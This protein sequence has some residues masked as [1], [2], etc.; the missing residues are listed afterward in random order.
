MMKSTCR[1]RRFR[2]RRTGYCFPSSATTF[3]LS[4]RDCRQTSINVSSRD[5]FITHRVRW[6]IICHPHCPS[7]RGRMKMKSSRRWRPPPPLCLDASSHNFR[8][9]MLLSPRTHANATYLTC[10]RSHASVLCATGRAIK[11]AQVHVKRA[12]DRP[13]RCVPAR[14]RI[15]SH[16]HPRRNP[17]VWRRDSRSRRES[18]P[19]LRRRNHR[20]RRHHSSPRA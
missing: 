6:W 7:A 13:A 19:S 18:H 16:Y 9:R 8:G 1:K 3:A 20:P 11:P 15:R 14:R 12:R 10:F 4:T 17:G 5:I 2:V